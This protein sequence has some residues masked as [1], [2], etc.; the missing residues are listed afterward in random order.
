[1]YR[2]SLL[3]DKDSAARSAAQGRIYNELGF[4]QRGLLEGWKSVNT[5]HSN[6]S[7]HRLL[8]DNYAALPRHEIARVS[9][10]LQSQLMQPVNITPIQPNLADN[11]MFIL[12]GF[13]PSDFSFNEFNPLFEYNRY[14]LQ[15]SGMYGSNGTWGDN[16]TLSGLHDNVSFSLGQFHY[17]TN[18]FREN[19]YL[20]KNLY[21]AFVQSQV[22]DD[23]NLQAEYRHEESKNGDLSLNFNL[24]NFS[25]DLTRR[26]TL[27][28]YR[29]GGRYTISPNSSLIASVIYQDRDTRQSYDEVGA[30]IPGLINNVLF[31]DRSNRK[32][33]IAEIQHYYNHSHFSLI[34]GLNHVNRDS[35]DTVTDT[36]VTTFGN[37]SSTT[38]ATGKTRNTSFYNYLKYYFTKQLTVTLGLA[39][40]FIDSDNAQRTPV[41][42][43]LGFEW[44]PT[45]S[46]TIR[47]AGFRTSGIYQ[48]VTQTIQPTQVA[49][50]NQFFDERD[51]T[52][53]WRYGAGIDHRFNEN[54]SIGAEYTERRLNIPGGFDG[55]ERTEQLARS[56]LYLTPHDSFS[57]AAEYYY[58]KIDQPSRSI[59]VT[60]LLNNGSGLYDTVETHR[61]PLTLSWFHESGFS[62]KIRNTYVQQKGVFQDLATLTSIPGKTS[63]ILTDMNLSY[64]LPK[65]YGILTVGINNLFDHRILFQN[66]NLNE[67]LLA[68]ERLLF[69]RI[70]VAF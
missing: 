12:N 61:L 14:A 51:G 70:S 33:F 35:N 19:N 68:P 53:S 7:A 54:L 57:V 42:P 6:Y 10:L 43:K 38:N 5:D 36:L 55:V 17:D 21:N 69:S 59:I 40:D 26:R 50:F 30:V 63:F 49:G 48:T 45:K 66:T 31:D 65:R 25:K 3:L 24:D 29:I 11:E 15:S 1:M 8:A 41:N 27:D 58:E 46:T 37:F 44:K 16:T 18:G 20:R 47:A 22:T 39:V 60:N 32:G 64:R 4:Q 13:G 52:L 28:S 2:S 34:S 62:F 23:L 9:E 56:Y 67:T